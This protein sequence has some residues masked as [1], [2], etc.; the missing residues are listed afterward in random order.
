MNAYTDP[1]FKRELV[2]FSADDQL[3]KKTVS[4][5]LDSKIGLKKIDAGIVKGT[6]K[7]IAFFCQ[8][9]LSKSRKK[10]QPLLNEYFNS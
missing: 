10:L 9:D 4:F 6:E 1:E 2:V 5:L 7:N 8:G 3:K